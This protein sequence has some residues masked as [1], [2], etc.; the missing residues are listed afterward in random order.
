MRIR[1]YL[2]SVQE[3]FSKEVASEWAL[4]N[5]ERNSKKMNDAIKIG[6]NSYPILNYSIGK[7]VWS[8]YP[9][10]KLWKELI[11]KYLTKRVEYLVKY[12]AIAQQ[13]D[14]EAASGLPVITWSAWKGD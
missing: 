1:A 6:W 12:I 11:T 13:F 14:D 4:K 3:D 2:W 9:R 5:G 7:L 8:T 10:H